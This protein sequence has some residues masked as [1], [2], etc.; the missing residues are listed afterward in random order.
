V[1]QVGQKKNEGSV[2][3]KRLRKAK[4]GGNFWN[5][6]GEGRTVGERGG[7]GAGDQSTSSLTGKNKKKHAKGGRQILKTFPTKEGRGIR[8]WSVGLLTKPSFEI[9]DQ[10]L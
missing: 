7:A 2:I 10:E 1:P 3:P 5:T 6:S 8:Q 4:R 9:D